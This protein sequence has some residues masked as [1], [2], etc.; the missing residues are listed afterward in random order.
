MELTRSSL[1]IR[2]KGRSVTVG[3]EA[4]LPG[5]GSPDFV[6]YENT[7]ETWDDGQAVSPE[8]KEEILRCIAQEAER[9]GIRVEIEA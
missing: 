6:V 5:Y 8:E 1:R 2:V 9:Q 7:I 4:Y 3:G